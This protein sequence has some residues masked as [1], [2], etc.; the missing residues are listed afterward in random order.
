MKNN[1]SWRPPD[2]IFKHFEKIVMLHSLMKAIVYKAF[3]SSN[4][5]QTKDRQ[6]DNQLYVIKFSNIACGRLKHI[7]LFHKQFI[8]YTCVYSKYICKFLVKTVTLWP[9]NLQLKENILWVFYNTC[10]LYMYS[11]MSKTKAHF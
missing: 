7:L 11:T 10:R 6:T 2:R 4:A 8:R 9:I 5:F 3:F 1:I